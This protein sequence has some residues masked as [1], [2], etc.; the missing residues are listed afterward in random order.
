MW[1]CLT[2]GA[3]DC[4]KHPCGWERRTGSANECIKEIKGEHRE[5]RGAGS[6]V[7]HCLR[8]QQA[9]GTHVHFLYRHWSTVECFHMTSFLL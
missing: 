2:G 9:A 5:T 8:A 4:V 1:R 3:A 6:T 7:T